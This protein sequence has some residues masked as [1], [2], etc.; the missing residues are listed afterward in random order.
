MCVR[1]RQSPACAPRTAL[2][3]APA[4][5]C[6]IVHHPTPPPSPLAQA[7]TSTEAAYLESPPTAPGRQ[8]TQPP[9][10]GAAAEEDELLG[11]NLRYV[12]LF[13]SGDASH[14]GAVF[15]APVCALRS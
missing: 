1:T 11:P 12:A 2:F 9:L 7:R 10:Q 15:P 3:A 6:L 4:L 14:V 13:S 8:P 5:S